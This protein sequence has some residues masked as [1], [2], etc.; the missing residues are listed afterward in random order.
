MYIYIYQDHGGMCQTR[1]GEK[2]DVN[3]SPRGPLFGG[4]WWAVEGWAL[5]PPD[6]A[7]KPRGVVVFG[8]FILGRSSENSMIGPG[9]S[10]HSIIQVNFERPQRMSQQL[11]IH[12]TCK[13][14]SFQVG[15]WLS[16]TQLLT[17][18]K[19][20]QPLFSNSNRQ[21]IKTS[22]TIL[23]SFVCMVLLMTYSI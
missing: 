5:K 2:L 17:K 16:F 15:E 22:C 10:I 12:I 18:L 14:T 21:I 11:V 20:I 1:R 23:L 7:E 4:R 3:I 13:T 19:P 8:G 6:R 9:V